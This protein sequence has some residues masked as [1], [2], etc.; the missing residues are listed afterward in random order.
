MRP[1]RITFLLTTVYYKKHKSTSQCS[2]PS[3]NRGVPERPIISDH[4]VRIK[5]E[6]E[7]RTGYAGRLRLLHYTSRQIKVVLINLMTVMACSA[8]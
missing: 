6:L 5:S 3:S 4:K 2:E 7:S 8:D 1:K